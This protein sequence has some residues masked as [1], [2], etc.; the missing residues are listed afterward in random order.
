MGVRKMSKL[1]EIEDSAAAQ[2]YWGKDVQIY[3][4]YKKYKMAHVKLPRMGDV[5]FNGFQYKWDFEKYQYF[6]TH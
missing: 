1:I 5:A 6:V 3:V 2:R 4:T